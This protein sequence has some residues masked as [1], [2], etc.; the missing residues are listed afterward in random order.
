MER[1]VKQQADA[2]GKATGWTAYRM[3]ELL[4]QRNQQEQAAAYFGKAVQS[5][6]Y[7]LD[8]QLKLALSDAQ[9]QRLEPARKRLEKLLEEQP[10]YVSAMANLGFVCLQLGD[11]QRAEYWY[12]RGM[13]LD[14]DN[15][16]AIMNMI[17]LHL[18]RGKKAEAKRMLLDVLK[19]YPNHQQA[20]QLLQYLSENA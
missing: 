16:A 14:P 4:L 12:R 1:W 5:M 20:R 2:A 10:K 7:Q 8:F 3:A 17:G 15:Q 11:E 9:A 18:Y 6:P 19:K 13:A